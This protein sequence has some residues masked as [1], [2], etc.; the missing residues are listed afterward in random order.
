MTV[1][2][3]KKTGINES[4]APHDAEA[5]VI[6]C[7]ECAMQNTDACKDCLVT[8]ILG[9]E[10]GDAL[11]IDAEEARAVRML[12]KVGLVPG[13]RHIKRVG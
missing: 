9:R 6:D 12:T 1:N 11:V 10:A 7:E 13:P 4:I 5:L 3:Q 8:F 2:V